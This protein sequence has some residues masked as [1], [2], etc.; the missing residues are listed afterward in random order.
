MVEPNSPDA[1]FRRRSLYPQPIAMALAGIA[2]AQTDVRR[3]DAALRAGEVLSRYIASVAVASFAARVGAD[4]D[5]KSISRPSGN[6]SWG[7]YIDLAQ[8]AAKHDVDH[9]ARPLLF[10]FKDKPKGKGQVS[11]ADRTLRGLLKLR[12]DLGHDISGLTEVRATTILGSDSP[13]V[14]LADALTGFSKLL[15]C[16]LF[17]IDTLRVDRKRHYAARQWLMGDSPDPEGPIIELAG[18]VDAIRAPYIAIGDKAVCLE[19]WLRWLVVEVHSR[20]ALAILDGVD[21]KELR[22]QTMGSVKLT[23]NGDSVDLLTSMAAGRPVPAESGM[24]AD[25]RSLA[26]T[27]DE[28]RRLFLSAAEYVDRAIPWGD[29]DPESL[30]WYG[31][32]LGGA[33]GEEREIISERL[34][35]G[36]ASFEP[37]ELRQARLLFGKEHVVRGLL[38]RP[39]VDLRVPTDGQER[40]SERL[41]VE[42]NVLVALRKA[43]DFLGRHLKVAV[44]AES[45]AVRTGGPSY[46]TVREALVNL[47]I[48]QDYGDPSAAG[49]IELRPD[50]TRLFNTGASLIDDDGLAVGGKSQSRNALIARGLRLAGF[51]ELAGSGLLALQ[52]AFRAVGQRPAVAQSDRSANTFTLTIDWR[53]L[54]D[55][56]DAIWKQKIGARVTPEQARILNLAADATGLRAVDAMA[57]TGQSREETEKSLTYLVHQQLLQT[58][59]DRYL[60]AEHLK[61]LV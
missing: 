8:E 26:E 51:A 47:L 9:P 16:P 15:A 32:L 1:V 29:F 5:G 20:Y 58:D 11:I 48:H 39:L 34:F 40:W 50:Y 49:Q 18:P 60:L 14:L 4:T 17:V 59:G 3:V 12:N 33:V 56:F 6:L 36:R 21:D 42:G 10:P 2:S 57:A 22:Y 44:S 19:P 37:N 45:L 31:R 55:R 13:L 35:D 61:D 7:S 53:P 38:G 46:L 41:L 30:K 23:R 54:E 25:G 24:L 28:Q 27:W 52:R 43:V